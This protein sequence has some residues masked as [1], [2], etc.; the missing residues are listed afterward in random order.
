MSRVWQLKRWFGMSLGGWWWQ[1]KNK[2]VGIWKEGLLEF[3]CVLILG[4]MKW[5]RMAGVIYRWMEWLL[6]TW[7][8]DT[9]PL[10]APLIAQHVRSKVKERPPL[11]APSIAPLIAPSIA[12]SIAPLIAQHVRSGVYMGSRIGLN[13]IIWCIWVV[14][15]EVQTLIFPTT[16]YLGKSKFGGRC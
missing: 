11:I 10:I 13:F 6:C 12:P 4:S 3:L 2:F 8:T 14:H 9:P 16:I 7:V 5:Y 1:R 15:L